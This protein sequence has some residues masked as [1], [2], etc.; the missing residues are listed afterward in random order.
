MPGTGVSRRP[1]T[2]ARPT[3][4]RVLQPNQLGVAPG[5]FA[6]ARRNGEPLSMLEVMGAPFDAV[7]TDLGRGAADRAA[8]RNLR[9]LLGMPRMSTMAIAAV[10]N[11]AVTAMPAGQAFVNVGVWNG[12][13]LLAGMAGNPDAD[14]VGIDDFS[15]F[16]GPREELLRRFEAARRDRHAIFEMDYRDYFARVHDRPIGVYMYDGEHSYDN[17]M[18]GLEAAEPF[19]ADGCV[20]VVDDANLEEPRQATLDFIARHEGRYEILADVRTGDMRHPTFWNGLLVLRKRAPGD[21]P[22][23]PVPAP[24]RRTRLTPGNEAGSGAALIVVRDDEEEEAAE[25]ALQAAHDQSW[26]P[27]EVIVARPSELADALDRC[28]APVVAFADC[29]APLERDAVE[30]SLAFPQETRFWQGEPG[31]DRIAHLRERLAA[32]RDAEA[33][34]PPGEPFVLIGDQVG[35][36]ATMGAGPPLA[37]DDPSRPLDEIGD[38]EAV[39]KLRRT[40]AR[41]VVVLS[42]RFSWIEQRPAVG[43]VLEHDSTTLLAN[44]RVRVYER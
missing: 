7:N 34:L 26:S 31:Q 28:E 15:Q 25:L 27:L 22:A 40:S 19:Y 8:R 2:L 16:G 33:V 29:A 35:L 32:G 42:T 12:F 18:R 21:P 43:R 30:L 5:R 4:F 17:Q 37:L 44:E 38:E 20:L 13:T 14:C 39:E 6:L 10:L 9:G 24:S 36:A 41:R 3:S 11:K 1:D 23:E